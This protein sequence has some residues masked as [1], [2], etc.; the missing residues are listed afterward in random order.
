[1]PR[2]LKEH[3]LDSPTARR[4]LRPR[5]E[6]YWRR[7]TRRA[8]LGYRRNPVGEGKWVARFYDG[9]AYREETLGAADDGCEPDGM[10]VL[11]FTQAHRLAQRWFKQR[12]LVLAGV[13]EQQGP[14]TVEDCARDYLAW[15][16][17][18]RRS[19]RGIRYTLEGYVLPAF[20]DREVASLT[21]TELRLWLQEIARSRSRR[22][23]R[24]S[25]EPLTEEESRRRKATANRV[26]AAFRAALNM[27]FNE[28]RV[29][30][31]LAW[32]RVKPFRN[33]DRP[34]VRFLELEEV[35]ALIA[36]CEPDFRLLVQGALHTGCRY[37]ELVGLRV[38]GYR[39]GAVH[40]HETKSGRPRVVFLS[41]EG[42]EF[43][44]DLVEGAGPLEHVFL[45]EDGTT[46]QKSQQARRMEAAS[47]AAGIEPA[48][49]FHVLRHTYASHYLMNG[50]DLAGLSRQLGHADTRMTM[51]HYSHL[52]EGWRRE[53]A[54]KFAPRLAVG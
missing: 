36:A 2:Q 5:P 44:E 8:H 31:D 29:A 51:R 46:W 53:A 17:D 23:I 54:R 49:T 13:V 32:R 21:T 47:E 6:P 20:G 52:A 22:L 43:F 24:Q 11:D 42:E 33:V 10:E 16:V 18:H 27:A 45:R 15:Y 9:R 40:L 4:R 26:W 50:G 25:T 41:E 48:A 35:R 37:G 7:V 1:M 19:I 3:H 12:G 30:S 14:Y 38:D 28:G 34:R 39:D